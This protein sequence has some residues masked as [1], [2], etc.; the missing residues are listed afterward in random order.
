MRKESGN[1]CIK[2][3]NIST[4]NGW[5]D[6]KYVKQAKIGKNGNFFLGRRF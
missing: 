6:R 4:R 1:Q 3:N 5:K 2:T